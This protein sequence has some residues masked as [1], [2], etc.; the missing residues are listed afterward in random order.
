MLKKLSVRS[1][2]FKESGVQGV[3]RK[4]NISCFP[5]P[6]SPITNHQSPITNHQSPITNHQSPITNHQSPIN[7]HQ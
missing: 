6:Q 3:R 4:I 2:E 5:S 7:N 1:Q